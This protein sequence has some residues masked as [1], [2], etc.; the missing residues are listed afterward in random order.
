MRA[1]VGCVDSDEVTPQRKEDT[2]S[3]QAAGMALRDPQ[4]VGDQVGSAIESKPEGLELDRPR[5]QRD[6]N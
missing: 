2:P 4:V 6:P 5:R 3:R 1:S